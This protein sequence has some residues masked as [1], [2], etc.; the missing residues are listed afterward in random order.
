MTSGT[1]CRVVAAIACSVSAAWAGGGEV[2]TIAALQGKA[3]IERGGEQ[4]TAEIGS[5]VG[6]GDVLVT[7]ED[8]KLRIVFQDDSVLSLAENSRVLIDENVFDLDS[9]KAKSLFELL[10]GKVNAAVSEYYRRRGNAYEIRTDTAVAGV[11]GTEFAVRFDPAKQLTEI[12]GIDGTVEVQSVRDPQA[13]TV[14]VTAHEI[15]VVE[16]NQPPT[17]P[18]RLEEPLFRERIEGFDFISRGRPEGLA[19]TAV[20]ASG[21]GVTRFASDKVVTAGVAPGS[22]PT[23]FRNMGTEGDATAKLGQPPAGIRFAGQ[24]G[25]NL[26]Q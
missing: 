26:G 10:R 18:R 15:T 13:P 25:I 22:E 17:P 5:A 1:L 21:A 16:E 11:R 3:H 23:R 24:L 8:G 14:L 19:V 6:I 9:G 12:I 2:G 4:V 7:A 20:L